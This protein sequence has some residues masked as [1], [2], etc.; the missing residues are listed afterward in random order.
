M[1]KKKKQ[2]QKSKLSTK[3]QTK[4]WP[5]LIGILVLTF[6][7]YANTLSH[8]YAL[9][10]FSAIKE[11]YVTKQ[12]L[13]GVKTI[14]TEHYRFGY[15][16]SKASLYRPF[17]L[18]TFALDWQI[19][20]D[21]SSFA[22]FMNVLLYTFCGMLV[23]LLL[24]K[25]LKKRSLIWPL[26]ISLLF[27][28]HPVHV[29][30][31][32][33]IKSRDEI[34]A[35]LFCFA[36]LWQFWKYLETAK[37]TALFL[38]VLLYALA[39][40][41]KESAIT[42]IAIYP[43]V[44]YFFHK[45]EI[46]KLIPQFLIFLV[47]ALLYL[48][49]RSRIVGELGVGNISL[50]DNA[51][52]AAEHK[53]GQFA[54][55]VA[56]LVNYYQ[57]M[58]VPFDLNH[59][60]GYKSIMPVGF[61]HWKFIVGLLCSLG[62][63]L[64]AILKFKDKSILSFSILFFALTFSILSN[65]VIPIGTIYGERLLFMPILGFCMLLVA[66]AFL[67]PHNKSNK[68]QSFKKDLENAKIPLTVIGLFLLFF[69]FKTITRNPVWKNSYTLYKADVEKGSEGAKLNYH[70]GLEL[71]KF[72]LDEKTPSGEKQKWLNQAASQFQKAIDIYPD[73]HDAYAQ[74][75]LHHYRSKNKQKAMQAYQKSIELKPNNAKV[76]SN[77]GIIYF[78]EG[79]LDK[80][81]EVYEKAVKIDPRFPDALRN[82]GSVYAMK[83]DFKK[84]I[85]YFSTALKYAPDDPTL[86][87]Y[88]QSAKR[89]LKAQQ[90]N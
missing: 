30:A 23:F 59:D 79:N 36:S 90:N 66:L 48:F 8:E 89:D 86:K 31:V 64:L 5:Y 10:D 60:L 88:L 7:L 47:P 15:W 19:A 70:Y 33:N 4:L 58:L 32:A 20:P 55:A 85:Q 62:L 24:T 34:L 83:K 52:F 6:V 73:Y 56:T 81:Q 27:I 71:V 14:W 13:G 42:F 74:M 82:L 61:G 35:F 53:S 72:G 1:S 2:N 17:T 37:A 26:A 21:S 65:V 29:E 76:Y 46:V 44:T 78:E 25:L 39:L 77:M 38:A 41:S 80:A 40:F 63:G 45:R 87:T 28:A 57:V 84:A 9:D 11:N 67:L 69:C 43:L 22:H 51:M 68:N 16:N 12:G 3:P 18:M 50:L 75:G 49:I 54:T